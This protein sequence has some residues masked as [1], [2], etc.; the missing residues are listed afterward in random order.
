MARSRQ[1]EA[2]RRRSLARL[3][4]GLPPDLPLVVGEDEHTGRFYVAW[5]GAPAERICEGRY[6]VVTAF[7]RGALVGRA[8]TRQEPNAS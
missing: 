6:E 7:L 1:F 8:I 3:R 2:L 5:T 4:G